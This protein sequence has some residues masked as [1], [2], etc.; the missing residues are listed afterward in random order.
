MNKSFQLSNAFQMI[1]INQKIKRH[2]YCL[3][4]L[5]LLVP[6]SKYLHKLN[7]NLQTSKTK[8]PTFLARTRSIMGLYGWI[9][10]IASNK[11][12]S[13]RVGTQRFVNSESMRQRMLPRANVRS[14]GQCLSHSVISVPQ[15]Q[16]IKA[17]SVQTS[18]FKCQIVGFRPGICKKT[19]IE[20]RR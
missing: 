15:R 1:G 13:V 10:T 5:K 16:N 4:R 12:S 3:H 20:M 8:N 19:N 7:P 18:K 9:S 14:A 6:I 17:A 2:N 11:H